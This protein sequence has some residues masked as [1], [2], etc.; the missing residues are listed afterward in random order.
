MDLWERGQHAGLV[1][2]TKAEGAAREGKATF[3]GKDEDDTV[4][5]DFHDTVLSGKLQQAVR[6]A[7]NRD[8]GGCLLP[9]DQ[10]TKTERPVAEVLLEK[11]SDMRVPPLKILRANPSRS[12][13]TC[14]KQY[15]STSQRMT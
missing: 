5:W 12:M 10:C 4:A 11:H 3:R 9:D 15:P 2:D 13:R 1:G 6:W 7:T 14:L 8:G